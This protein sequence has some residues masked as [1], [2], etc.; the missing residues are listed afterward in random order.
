MFGVVCP[1]INDNYEIVS[2]Q[3]VSKTVDQAMSTLLLKKYIEYIETS[4]TLK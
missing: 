4:S 1:D 3:L 2:W